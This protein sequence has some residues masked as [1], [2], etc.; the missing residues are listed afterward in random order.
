MLQVRSGLSLVFTVYTTIII[1]YACIP[2]LLLQETSREIK[3]ILTT[4]LDS[5]IT[6]TWYQTGPACSVWLHLKMKFYKNCSELFIFFKNI[7]PSDLIGIV[8]VQVVAGRLMAGVGDRWARRV[9]VGT[10]PCRPLR[11]RGDQVL[12]NRVTGGVD[13]TTRLLLC[14]QTTKLLKI[15]FCYQ[16]LRKV[17]FL[18]NT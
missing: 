9:E 7:K 18:G 5:Q 3:I 13:E 12:V 16:F 1:C 14:E 6:T 10:A 11:H 8:M 15:I 4:W 17:Y 2:V